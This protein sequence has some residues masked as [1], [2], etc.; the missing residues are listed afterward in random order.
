MC[1]LICD[2]II[3]CVCRCDEGKINASDN[4][5][6]ENQKERKYGNNRNFCIKLHLK[7]VLGWNSQL[8]KPS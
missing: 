8:A 1:D 4:I 6:F 3:F 7:V 5:M 2:V